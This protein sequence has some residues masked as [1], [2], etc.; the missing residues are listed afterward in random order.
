MGICLVGH[1]WCCEMFFFKI[2][3]LLFHLD[4]RIRSLWKLSLHF[5]WDCWMMWLLN[6]I[7][8]RKLFG[9]F[10][11]TFSKFI[12]MS[13]LKQRKKKTQI[14]RRLIN[15]DFLNCNEQYFKLLAEIMTLRHSR[16]SRVAAP[17]YH[18]LN[19]ILT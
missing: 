19:R 3:I 15:Q 13:Y 16:I 4:T 1:L 18:V 7:Q 5:L 8:F 10:V 17:E 11:F 2:F 6:N 14:H 9:F 12:S